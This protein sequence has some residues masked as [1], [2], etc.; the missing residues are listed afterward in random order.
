M[1]VEG[2]CGPRYIATGARR[3]VNRPDDGF[4]ASRCVRV[5]DLTARAVDRRIG[6][7]PVGIDCPLDDQSPLQSGM[8]RESAVVARASVI[9]TGDDQCADVGDAAPGLP[10]VRT[11]WRRCH[12]RVGLRTLL[13]SR[14]GLFAEGCGRGRGARVGVRGH[15]VIALSPVTCGIRGHFAGFRVTRC[16]QSAAAP[17]KTQAEDAAELDATGQAR[18]HEP[19]CTARLVR[20]DWKILR[21]QKRRLPLAGW[22]LPRPGA[23][24]SGG[25]PLPLTT[26]SRSLSGH[27]VSGCGWGTNRRVSSQP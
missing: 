23:T 22:R 10:S 12:D 27:R 11:A 21:A 4:H 2:I 6:Y 18:S 26:P 15:A 16:S 8:I 5:D 7:I 24:R 13:E 25:A 14:G 1:E 20:T 17:E 19:Q 9:A 3:K